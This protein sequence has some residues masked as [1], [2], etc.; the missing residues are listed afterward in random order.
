M[1]DRGEYSDRV[2]DGERREGLEKQAGQEAG[3]KRAARP[4]SCSARF[5]AWVWLWPLVLLPLLLLRDS[6]AAKAGED[7]DH[8]LRLFH[9]G[10]LTASQQEAAA[11]YVRYRGS[12]PEWAGKFLLLEAESM[13]YR[14]MDGDALALLAYYPVPGSA[15]GAS[16]GAVEKL[17]IEA[18]A[19]TSL[20]RFGEAEGRLKRAE[21]FC[22]G[23]NFSSCGGVLT[24]CANL[25]ISQ[26]EK[27]KAHAYYVRALA[28]ARE[29]HDSFRV[30]HA[31]LSMSYIN[32]Q[33]GHFDEAID[34]ARSAYRA[35]E[36]RGYQDAAQIAA[37]NI[38]WAYYELGDD[39]RALAQ[40]KAAYEAAARLGDA[41]SEIRW[42]LTSGYVYRDSGDLGRAEQSFHSALML[43]R[44]I[45]NRQDIVNTLEDTAELAVS[46]GSLD[47][48]RARL[49][50]ALPI[51][52]GGG[53]KPRP[54]VMLTEGELAA[55]EHEYA[56]ARGFY[57][58]ILSD[59][60]SSVADRLNTGNDL[61]LVDEAQGRPG[62]AE[63]V[64]RRTLAEW[65]AAWERLKGTESQLAFGMNASQIYEDYVRLLVREGRTDAALAVADGS[66]ARTL[67][68][69]L[70]APLTRTRALSP[71]EIARRTNATLL[72]YWLGDKESYLW[73]ITPVRTEFFR[74]PARREIAAHVENYNK[75][76][77][78]LRDPAAESNAD[79][80]FLYATLV[81]PA[82]KL[83]DSNK[84]AGG[85]VIVL[86][87][88]TL[89]RLNFETLPVP[90]ADAG[91]GAGA[92]AKAHY[93]IEDATL[94]TAPSL[95]LLAH[96]LDGRAKAEAA[97]GLLLMGNPVEAD[98]EYPPLPLFGAEM[99]RV[100][101]HFPAAGTAVYGG[102]KATPEAYEDAH[103]GNY[104]YIHFVSHATASEMD[105]L[106]SAIILSR[107]G[108]SRRGSSRFGGG[109]D[110]GGYKLYAREI[111]DHPLAAR[112]VTVSA[113]YGSG[114]RAY[115][116]EGLVGLAWA[117]LRA[118]AR[119]VVAALWEVSD[120]STPRLM[121][122]LYAG[123]AAGKSPA[124]ALR[125]A[126]LG[127][128]HSK[129]RFRLPFYW[130]AFE[131]YSRE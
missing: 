61:A 119:Q 15:A 53:R 108:S 40:Y 83:I 47:E 2:G 90:D 129:G 50:E 54:F 57:H 35:A 82:K 65:D 116:G 22:S 27:T 70:G 4:G 17:T 92:A 19:L 128:L 64:Y 84:K 24:E 43:A 106:E 117:F 28:D 105:P 100:E 81:A 55:A 87:D 85:T 110:P 11:G 6:R 77:L 23:A 91:S 14:G 115:T 16:D 94:I 86:P 5:S 69:G 31:L 114:T 38:G 1:R 7:Y 118:G 13:L 36:Q 102:G 18:G 49:G 97:H 51:E 32:L 109:T 125:E 68:Y 127:L 112:L 122:A 37:G 45:G 58:A 52:T 30:A 60:A 98:A 123:I 96:G 39:E 75:A 93:L 126:K 48:A 71:R 66:R 120:G 56:K 8:A 78:A 76:I 74:L 79:G 25:A 101:S 59:A 42:L 21:S 121:D 104:E 29:R 80:R 72:F 63:R 103:P 130:A 88:A 10:W 41:D 34:W 20:Q 95:D 12:E 26:G 124:E 89:S 46:R 113:C 44:K 33:E 107:P 62:E 99:R 73:A 67:A 111:V 3:G 131:I 9:E